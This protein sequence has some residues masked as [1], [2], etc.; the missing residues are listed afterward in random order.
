MKQKVRM[1][2]ICLCFLLLLGCGEQ[3]EVTKE[4]TAFYYLNKDAT[5]IEAVYEVLS[6]TS[7]EAV[8]EA[9]LDRLAK[10]PE[11]SNLQ[12]PLGMGFSLLG[13]SFENRKVILDFSDDY[14]TVTGTTE[15]LVRAAI[16]KTLTQVEGIKR[17]E[18]HVNGQPLTDSLGKNVGSMTADT[19]IYNDGNDINTYEPLKFKLYFTNETADKLLITT[20]EKHYSTNTPIERFVVEELIA[21]PSGQ[22][23][24]LYPTVNAET[25]IINVM[26]TDGTCFVNLDSA[27]LNGVGNVSLDMSA[28]SIAN[29][30]LELSNLSQVQI[31]ING[32]A[33]ELFTGIYPIPQKG[34]P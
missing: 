31:L 15:V 10:T 2:L 9:A 22:V 18:F 23:E 25:K 5:K 26:T 34:E 4:G 17:V 27:F 16:V 33:S 20:R 19:F 7:P 8:I 28:Y 30:L 14:K 24:G 6:D 29:S 32:E 12:A 13:K 21:G 11:Q 3:Q 1:G